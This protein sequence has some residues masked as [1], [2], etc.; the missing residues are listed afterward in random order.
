M[1]PRQTVNAIAFALLTGSSCAAPTLFTRF[2]AMDDFDLLHSAFPLQDWI[3]FARG[4]HER[5]RVMQ[6]EISPVGH[7]FVANAIPTPPPEFSVEPIP[8]WEILASR[9]FSEHTQVAPSL[10]GPREWWPK[11]PR[12]DGRDLTYR[13]STPEAGRFN[14]ID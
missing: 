1:H 11:D 7:V 8:V 14:G 13:S 6:S 2:T 5:L 10:C 12:D 3:S 4:E 9:V